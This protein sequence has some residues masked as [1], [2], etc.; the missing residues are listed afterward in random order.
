MTDQN[1]EELRRRDYR[2]GYGP[3]HQIPTVQQ[4][5]NYKREQKDD[6]TA[7][8]TGGEANESGEPGHHGR[9]LGRWFSSSNEDDQK[10]SSQPAVMEGRWQGSQA[11]QQ[12]Q[13]PNQQQNGPNES[14]DMIQ[15]QD[16]PD[17][18]ESA[19]ADPKEL[20]LIHI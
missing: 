13:Q 5:R 20:S 14:N 18:T 1:D 19:G 16:K 10:S 2:P 7:Q 3:K 15:Q 17:T 11:Q 8:Q 12:N 9:G 6:L 4:Y